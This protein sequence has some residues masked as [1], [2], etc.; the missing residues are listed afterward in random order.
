MKVVIAITALAIAAVG[1]SSSADRSTSSNSSALTQKFDITTLKGKAASLRATAPRRH[2]Q[3]LRVRAAL[4][5]WITQQEQVGE[6]SKRD[7]SLLERTAVRREP[8][9]ILRH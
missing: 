2:A 1:C 8:L 7:F 9:T 5:A 4:R 6:G 3:A